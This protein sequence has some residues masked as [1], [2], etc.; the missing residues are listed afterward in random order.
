MLRRPKG[1]G[2]RQSGR[3]QLHCTTQ[4]TIFAQSL[5]CCPCVSAEEAK[6]LPDNTSN[7]D[8]LA[9]YG[10]FKQVCISVKCS[11]EPQHL[12][13]ACRG[14]SARLSCFGPCP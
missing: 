12:L 4:P 5:Y 6:G 2:W 1:Q 10:L 9:L 7:D 13:E 11:L 3:L 14:S 8:K